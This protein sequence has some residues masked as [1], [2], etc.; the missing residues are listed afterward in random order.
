MPLIKTQPCHYHEQ[1]R[2][3]FGIVNAITHAPK[4]FSLGGKGGSF[5]TKDRS[6][7]DYNH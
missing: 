4:P 6:R 5:G 3:H 7:T 1:L 2:E